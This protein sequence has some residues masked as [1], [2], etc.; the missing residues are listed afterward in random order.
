MI[1]SNQ[2][3][4]IL[5]P[6]RDMMRNPYGNPVSDAYFALDKAINAL[7]IDIIHCGECIYKPKEIPDKYYEGETKV[8][9]P[10][11]NG[12]NLC[13]C[14]CDDEFYSWVPDDNWFCANGKR[15]IEMIVIDKTG[16]Q[17]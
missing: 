7:K 5:K 17:V 15:K 12:E 6:M 11:I 4:Q 14:Q 9:F 13:P 2:A 8:Y 10:E 1:D 3:I 16:V